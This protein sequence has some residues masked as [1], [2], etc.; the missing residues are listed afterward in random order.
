MK[1]FG[2]ENTFFVKVF[3]LSMIN[4][5]KRLFFI[6]DYKHIRTC[7]FVDSAGD[8]ICITILTMAFYMFQSPAA[9]QSVQ[10][11]K[12]RKVEGKKKKEVNTSVVVF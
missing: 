12:E 8:V 7:G 5:I 3:F 11:T 1:Y 10:K 4:W 6:F 9:S 2:G